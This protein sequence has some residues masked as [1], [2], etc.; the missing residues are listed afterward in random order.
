MSLR[1]SLRCAPLLLAL[2]ACAYDGPPEVT[3]VAPAGGTF[4]TGDPLQ[5]SFSEPIDPATLDLRIWPNRRDTEG[6]LPEGL[7]PKVES[8][9]A[10]SPR[11]GDA[12]LTLAAD[13]LSATITLAP[14]TLGRPDVP[15]ILEVKEGLADEGGM[16]SGIARLFDFQFRHSRHANEA[17]VPFDQGVYLIVTELNDPIP[18]VITLMTDFRIAPD[19]RTALAGAECDEINGAP[20]NTRDPTSLI[21]DTTDMGFVVLASGFVTLD[22]EERFLETDPVAINL[23]LGPITVAIFDVRLTAKIV[24]HPET[25]VDQL[26][27]I[28]SYGK[29]TLNPGEDGFDYPAGNAA[30][31]SD[32]VPDDQVPEGTPQLCGELCGAVTGAC[33]PPDDFPPAD[34]CG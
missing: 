23:S 24:K 5:L 4:V 25:G 10:A 3:L 9:T 32:R 6:E 19:G 34:F 14:A 15:L 8:C 1:T 7:T 13:N 16:A 12:T 28:L 22:G 20:R 27:G 2:G 17:P 11:C 21:V 26:E 31:V 33:H 29:I 18:S 30:F